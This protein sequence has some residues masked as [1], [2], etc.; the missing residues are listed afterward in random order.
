MRTSGEPRFLP[1]FCPAPRGGPGVL[2]RDPGSGVRR[3]AARRPSRRSS[4]PG[5]EGCAATATRPA[6]ATAAAAAAASAAGAR[7]GVPCAL[8]PR[9]RA[10][11]RGNCGL[12]P[13]DLH[14]SCF[15][16]PSF[17]RQ[18]GLGWAWGGGDRVG[19]GAPGW[20]LRKGKVRVGAG[21]EER[22]PPRPGTGLRRAAGLSLP[23]GRALLPGS[24]RRGWLLGGSEAS[25]CEIK[26][27]KVLFSPRRQRAF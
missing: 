9:R 11:W 18:P 10:G 2:A 27:G 20:G 16:V 23:G 12:T 13:L 14:P 19:G 26:R 1:C 8:R 15:P 22:T 6:A 5:S 7:C 17:A 21:G 3:V 24:W 25:P 4:A